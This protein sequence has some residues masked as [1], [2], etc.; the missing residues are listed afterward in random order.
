MVKPNPA[1]AR[2]LAGP[3]A[4]TRKAP[5]TWPGRASITMMFTSCCSVVLRVKI[6]NTL[7]RSG[8]KTISAVIASFGTEGLK[9]PVIKN[10][11]WCSQLKK[12]SPNPSRFRRKRNF[13]SFGCPEFTQPGGVFLGSQNEK[14][15][16][17]PTKFSSNQIHHRVL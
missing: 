12:I 11:S 10:V 15:G 9:I 17:A 1:P 13:S 7:T 16:R 3:G 14:A 6:G 4:R 5:G 2:L 8:G